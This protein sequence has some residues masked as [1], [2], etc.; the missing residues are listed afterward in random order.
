MSIRSFFIKPTST[1]IVKNILNDII[2]KASAEWVIR[3]SSAPH[4]CGIVNFNSTPLFMFPTF[5]AGCAGD[6][7]G[8]IKAKVFFDIP[9]RLD[10]CFFHKIGDFLK[11]NPY[12]D[13]DE[14]FFYLNVIFLNKQYLKNVIGDNYKKIIDNILNPPLPDSESDSDDDSVCHICNKKDNS[15]GLA[16]GDNGDECQVCKYCDTDGSN[17]NGWGNK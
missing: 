15:V 11:Q 6:P 3:N 8:L 13:W 10:L 17:Y 5:F 2:D 12:V 7:K 1:E 9:K 16:T 14:Q 4:R